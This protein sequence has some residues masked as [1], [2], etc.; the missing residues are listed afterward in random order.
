MRDKSNINSPKVATSRIYLLGPKQGHGPSI[1]KHNVCSGR[2][3]TLVFWRGNPKFDP[4]ILAQIRPR[5]RLL[6][7]LV[8]GDAGP[9]TPE[10]IGLGQERVVGN[11]ETVQTVS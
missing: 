9:M 11:D 10:F 4:L 7:R 1:F 2:R 3:F 5:R 8:R 6:K